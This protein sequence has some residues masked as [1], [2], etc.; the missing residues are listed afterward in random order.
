[1]NR[2]RKGRRF[3]GLPPEVDCCV[4]VRT[5]RLFLQSASGRLGCYLM[6]WHVYSLP[7]P[8]GGYWALAW[9]EG[10]PDALACVLLAFSS[11]HPAF[12]SKGMG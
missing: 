12:S 8:S 11:D 3:V 7:F 6:C 5:P 10:V 4:G 1:M 9:M 2:V